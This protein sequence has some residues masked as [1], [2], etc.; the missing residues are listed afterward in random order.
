[1]TTTDRS[2]AP[3]PPQRSPA[4]PDML[5]QSEG[6]ERVLGV[7]LI[8][9]PR[10]SI[11]VCH[12]EDSLAQ[13]RSC[14]RN[15]AFDYLPV[16]EACQKRMVGLL[17]ARHYA[18]SVYEGD[19][20]ELVRSHMCPLSE[21]DLIGADATILD[22]IKRVRPKPL[23]V[24]AGERIQGIVAWSDLQKLPVRSAIFALV[25]GFEL[26][27]Y[28]AISTAF[29]DDDG[30]QNLLKPARLK[31]AKDLYDKRSRNN[32]DVDLLLCTQFCDKREIL[33]RHLFSDPRVELSKLTSGGKFETAVKEI[34]KLR[35]N[36]THA[37][38]YATCWDDVE[39]LKQTVK[40]LVDLRKYLA[41]HVL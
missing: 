27:M 5:R 25:T 41:A 37:N 4:G 28:E 22:F 38:T 29:R 12:P 39:N 17:A 18:N 7:F 6:F 31:D 35:N 23:L 15:S 1:M 40:S 3:S 16:E 2:S 10:D 33:K 26:T 14:K 36:V 32:S 19:E 30:W 13:V 9:T 11:R 24:V 20:Q 8:A 34:E 21:A